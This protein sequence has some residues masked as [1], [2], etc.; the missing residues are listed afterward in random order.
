[1]T[2]A[3]AAAARYTA[4]DEVRLRLRGFGK[5]ITSDAARSAVALAAVRDERDGHARLASADAHVRDAV[6]RGAEVRVRRPR[7]ADVVDERVRLRIQRR[8]A[9]VLIPPV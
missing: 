5:R 6:G 1:M 9:D 7:A 4:L 8:R 2:I 3:P